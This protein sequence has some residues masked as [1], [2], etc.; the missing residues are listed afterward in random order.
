MAGPIT[1][2]QLGKSPALQKFVDYIELHTGEP[3]DL[4]RIDPTTH[5]EAIPGSPDN[6][7]RNDGIIELS[8]SGQKKFSRGV[9][10][11][12]FY[13][14]IHGPAQVLFLRHGWVTPTGRNDQPFEA[15]WALENLPTP[16]PGACALVTELGGAAEAKASCQDIPQSL[17]KLGWGANIAFGVDFSLSL[18]RTKIAREVGLFPITRLT[19]K[20]LTPIGTQELGATSRLVQTAPPV[21]VGAAAYFGSEIL[22]DEIMGW[23]PA[24]H[25]HERFAAGVVGGYYAH[26]WAASRI[27][28]T[29]IPISGLSTVE[30]SIAPMHFGAG[31]LTAGLVD[32]LIGDFWQEGS[33][34]R[35][36]V[37]GSAFFLPAIY[38]GVM[39]S[40]TLPLVANRPRLA[41]GGRIA[42]RVATLGFA[43]DLGFMGYH[44]LTEGEADGA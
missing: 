33:A 15:R 14:K 38:R 36:A 10:N 44:H 20:N 21:M 25:L 9:P 35:E 30:K 32:A 19:I 18:L 29:P 11:P 3:V 31:I 43:T 27:K 1:S 24:S 34:T 16:L 42:A 39:G 40:R 17:I 28:S 12:T 2:E 22:L 7:I 37:R 13:A 6:N 41:A 4:L 26:R 5:R 23:D 8:Y